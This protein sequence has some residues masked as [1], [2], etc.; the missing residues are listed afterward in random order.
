M[1]TGEVGAIFQISTRENQ[2]E[3]NKK[4]VCVQ[5]QTERNRAIVLIDFAQGE[6]ISMQ[7]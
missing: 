2:S 1:E 5:R 6:T 4:M 3:S 7:A